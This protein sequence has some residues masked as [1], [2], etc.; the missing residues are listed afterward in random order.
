MGSI[1]PTSGEFISFPKDKDGGFPFGA[2]E[3][4]L[5][6]GGEMGA[7]SHGEKTNYLSISLHCLQTTLSG[8]W[9]S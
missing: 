5:E 3:R 7:Q 4:L 1:L 9:S 8:T 6:T 2:K